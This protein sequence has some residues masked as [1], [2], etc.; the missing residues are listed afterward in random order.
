MKIGV[1]DSGIGGESVAQTLRRYFPD[2]SII[3]ADDRKNAPYG[4]KDQQEIISLVIEAVKPLLD[5]RCDI[6]VI[7]CNTATTSAMPSLKQQYPDRNFIGI[8]PMIEAAAEQSK[9]GKICVCA[10]PATLK[11]RRYR[12]LKDSHGKDAVFIEPDCHDW[13]QMI[14]D[15][16]VNEHIVNERLQFALNNG[17]DV[18]V[19]GCTHYHWI[20]DLIEK[21][22]RGRA[23]I[24]EPSDHV[25]MQIKQ[26][27][28]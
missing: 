15:N 11:S 16:D 17:A 2:A 23:T 20:K 1:F 14:E 3:L 26:L 7:A 10:T 8:E 22:A 9:T 18:I 27:A 28:D 25:A 5:A 21:I 13:A 12:E 19:L 4:S 24:I 6:I